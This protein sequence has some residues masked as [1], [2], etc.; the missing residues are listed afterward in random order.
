MVWA[1]GLAAQQTVDM[2]ADDRPL[3]ADFDEI[4]RIGSLDGETWETF[5]EIGGAAFDAEG[6]LYVLDRQAAQITVADRNGS[7]VRVIGR[8]GGG[9]LADRRRHHHERDRRRMAAPRR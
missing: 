7:F 4:F 6:N 3:A 8:Q 5:G 1:T 9:P 2:P